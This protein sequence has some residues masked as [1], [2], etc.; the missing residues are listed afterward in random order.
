MRGKIL[1]KAILTVLILIWAVMNLTPPQDIPFGDYIKQNASAEQGAFKAIVQKAEARVENGEEPSLFVALRTIGE[2]EKIDYVGYFPHIDLLDVKNRNRRNK[3]LLNELL[4][5]SQSPL[6]L[7]LDLKGGVGVTLKVAD[8]KLR[9]ESSTKEASA[10]SAD[11]PA[12]L[13]EERLNQAIE[14]MGNR[15]NGLGVTEPVIRAV[16]TD[17]IEIQM[18]GLSSRENPDVLD[19]IK[20]PARLEFRLVHRTLNPITTPED[21]F[22]PGYEVLV[23]EYEDLKTGEIRET[24]LFVKRIPEATGEIVKDAYPSMGE[25]GGM[26]VLM[27][28][29]SKGNTVF[30]RLTRR[31]AEENQRTETPGRLAIVLD[32]KLYSAPSVSNEI[33]GSAEITGSFTQREA[34][35][36]SNVL[37]NP[38][39]FE[40][41]VDQMYEVGPTLAQDARESSINASTL[42]ACLV[43]GFMILYYG[44]SGVVAVVSMSIS[45]LITLGILASIGATLTLPGIAALVLTIGM[46][47]D[48]NIL[49][50]ERIREELRSGKNLYPSL[51]GGY[52]KALS[53]IVDA[54]VTTL[55]IAT[56][57]IWLGTGPVKGFGVTLSIGICTSMFCA[58]VVSRFML[59]LT[60]GSGWIKKILRLN[61]FK[62]ST[63]DFLKFRRWAFTGSW[64]IVLAGVVTLVTREDIYGIDFTGGDEATLNF[65]Q[66]LKPAEITALAK[67]E[68]LGEVNPVYQT[69]LGEDKEILKLQT[70]F[71]R[72]AEAVKALQQAFPEAGLSYD[73]SIVQIGPSVGADI[74]LNAL[75]SVAV[76]L[77]G[78]L[79]YVALRFEI[80]YGIGAVVA[81][82]HDVLMTLGIFVMVG[83][84][85]TAPM[86]A[87]VLMIV[88]YSINDTIVVFDRIREELTLNPGSNL[89]KIVNLAINRVLSRSILT[90]ITT[91][92]AAVALYI[93]GAGVINDFAFVF[94]V[95]IITGTF[96]SIFIASPI[97]FWWHKGQRRH[98]E[99]R[100][101][102]T[103]AYEWEGSKSKAKS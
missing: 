17:R 36:L 68:D 86:V 78:I 93:F 95:G 48:A 24:P 64:I 54:N 37:N 65:E 89:R 27:N 94:I 79:L 98:V 33:S 55:I 45:L 13:R 80:G 2:Q 90:S 97:F 57:L 69:L 39:K 60:V 77:L 59:E 8:E 44:F 20:K 42:G 91:L 72:G 7:G 74:K 100:H 4:K 88:G 38:L 83:G 81:T 76:A 47:V 25:F 29:T 23:E 53:T 35:E 62:K 41:T 66:K 92:L 56:I 10:E 96:S 15:V 71:G 84:Q 50:F 82:I 103:P 43:I 14:V 51:L 70:Q 30:A 102:L 101:D 61:L 28:F 46:A 40:L 99:E 67:A 19:A 21:Q 58:L 3:I 12:Y 18:P 6:K 22:P 75:I 16:G 85:F 9:A 31:I 87:A 52:Q 32:G 1:G 49:I 34:I 11:I 63:F 73:G 26:R 5:R